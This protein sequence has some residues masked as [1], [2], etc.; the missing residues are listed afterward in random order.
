MLKLSIIIVSYNTATLTKRA[1][2]LAWQDVQNSELKNKAEI[3]VVDNNS[4]DNSPEVLKALQK[5]IGHQ[6]LKLFMNKHNHGFSAANNQALTKAQGEYL[7]LLNSD[8]EVRPGAISKLVTTFEQHPPQET[9]AHHIPDGSPWDRLGILAA[10]LKNPDLT[11]QPQ[12]GSFPTLLSLTAHWL[13]LDDIPV[14]GSLLPSTQH[15][16]R[17]ARSYDL[18]QAIIPQDWVGGTALMIK[19]EVLAEIGL[20]DEGIF[21]YGEDLE[22][23]WRAKHHHWDIG[24]VPQAE[25]IHLGTASSTPINALRGEWKNY[26]YVWSKH[27][28]LWQIP[29]VKLILRAGALLRT[30]VF[31]TMGQHRKAK[32]YAQ[33]LIEPW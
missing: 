3:I 23:C 15:T 33:L 5:K 28:P 12:G 14:I 17:R 26:V 11:T 8:T 13:M 31:G 21:M 16:G 29:L 27:Q 18:K 2:E 1:I 9:K 6:F 4:T 25:V 22:W 24:I 7:F 19:K 10:H 20:L 30:L 32:L